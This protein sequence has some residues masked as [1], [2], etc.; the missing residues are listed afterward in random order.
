MTIFKVAY[1]ASNVFIKIVCMKMHS[2]Y[3]GAGDET[4]R[5]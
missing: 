5:L 3:H 4:D 2:M 1:N